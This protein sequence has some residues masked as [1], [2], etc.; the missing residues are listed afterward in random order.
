SRDAQGDQMICP[1]VLLLGFNRPDT[2]RRVIESLRPVA[3]RLLFFAVDGPRTGKR[4]ESEQ[5]AAVRGL[6]GIIDW[7]CD[8]RTLFR[9]KNLGCKIAVSEAISWLF[10]NVEAGIVLEDDCV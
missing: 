7:D 9:E 1:P 5:V 4:E 8:V 10:D 2:T 6:T 3:P